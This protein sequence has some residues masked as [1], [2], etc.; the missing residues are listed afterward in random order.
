MNALSITGISLRVSLVHEINPDTNSHPMTHHAKFLYTPFFLLFSLAPFIPISAQVSNPAAIKAMIS[1]YK[2]DPRGPYLDIRWFCQDGSTRAARDPCPEVPGNQHA[3]YKAEVESLASKEHIY[4]GQ[5]LA[6]VPFADFWDEGHAQSR[7][8]Q[9]QLERYLM[10]IDNGWVNRRAQYYRGAVQVEDEN[11]WGIGFYLWLLE[12]TTKIQSQYFLIRQSAKDIPHKAD[13][14]NAQLVRSLSRTISDT[15]PAFLD[16]RV[17]IHGT[18]D[19]GD[20]K[21]VQDFQRKNKATIPAELTPKFDSLIQQMTIMYKPFTVSDFDA[22]I[23]RFPQESYASAILKNFTTQYT[24]LTSASDRCKLISHTALLLRRELTTPMKS[25]AR[26]AIIDISNKLEGLIRN[27]SAKWKPESLADLLTQTNC[28]AEAA[29]AFGF[30]ELWEWDQ[31]SPT[32]ALPS[33]DSISLQQLNDY[34][35]AARHVTEWAAGMVRAN[36]TPVLNLYRDF[37]PLSSGFYDDRIRSSVL[38]PLGQNASILGD[39]FAHQAG[40]ANAVMTIPDQSSIHGLNPGY[41]VG[42]LVVVTGSAESIKL[43]PEKIYVFNHPPADLKPVAGIATVTEGNMVSHVQLLA[44]N[45]GIPNAVL[46]QENMQALAA[47]NGT[48]V[49][50]AVSN[51]GTVIMKPATTMDSIENELFKQKK[52]QE[53]KISV[54]IERTVLDNPHIINLREVDASQSGK[55]CGPKAANLGQLKKMFP[56]HVVEGLVLPF[57]VF[58]Q[59]MNQPI[60]GSAITY[61]QVMNNI[62]DRGESMKSNGASDS[63][64]ETFVLQKLDSL[65]GLIKVMPF[66]PAFTYE[67]QQQFITVFGQPIGKVPVFVRSDTNMEDLK[68][69]TGAGLNLTVFNVVDSSKILQ[70]IR[71]VWASP[72]TERSYKW[73]QRYL[74]NPENVFPSILI[75]PSVNAD[76]SGVMIT[77]GITTG[78]EED[79][80]VA[81]NRGVGGAV[82]GQAAESWLLSDTGADQLVTPAREATYLSIPATGGSLKVKTTFDQRILTP[83]N[84]NT[85]RELSARI[86]KELPDSPG[87]HTTGPFDM[88]LGFKD[89]HLWLFQ[90]RPFVENKQA[91][92]SAYLQHITPVMDIY[93]PIPMDLKI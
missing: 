24:G 45:L 11:N 83:E 61:W 3:R 2:K 62:F 66:L 85:L 6:S 89:D 81:F 70:G 33:T 36:Y 54:P 51:K 44:R 71:D 38:L 12:D 39:A 93:R 67:L 37:E 55:I 40:F 18:P 86:L 59:H 13:N 23:K 87:I 74:N 79:I 76:H 60:P 10:S 64:I 53:E 32:L 22:Y 92:A 34:S 63:D 88:E 9:Y 68:D 16:L 46:S 25:L 8:I 17:K 14:N 7:L 5:I 29:T 28:L 49:F 30:L 91:A 56:D 47:F 78:R 19:Q 31:I 73:R 77:K 50:Y 35:E 43:S 57:S 72:Y 42:E 1:K 41:T 15:L 58:Y 80:T 65:R 52:R 90:V 4:M 26:L 84:L 20:I 48:K 75:I 21:R 27:E 69:F 82:D